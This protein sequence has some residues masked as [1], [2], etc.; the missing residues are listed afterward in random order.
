MIIRVLQEGD[1]ILC[2]NGES[3]ANVTQADAVRM[4]KSTQAIV[5]LTLARGKLE[6]AHLY[7]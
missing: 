3:T 4:L 6:A 1:V 7:P 5:T 2:I